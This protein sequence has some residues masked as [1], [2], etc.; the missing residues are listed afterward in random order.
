MT[1]D[2]QGLTDMVLKDMSHQVYS[3][4]VTDDAAR[5]KANQCSLD[6]LFVEAQE[7]LTPFIGEWKMLYKHHLVEALK[8]DE[9]ARE[10]DPPMMD[11]LLTENEGY[12]KLFAYNRAKELCESIVRMV[13]DPI[14]DGDEITRAQERICVTLTRAFVRRA[15]ESSLIEVDSPVK[16]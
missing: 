9:E 16:D 7:Q 11:P 10:E 3:H 5:C 13:T 4:M 1:S 6:R 12:I 8:E 15:T 14:L 2:I